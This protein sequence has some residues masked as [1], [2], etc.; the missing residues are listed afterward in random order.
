MYKILEIFHI[1]RNFFSRNF[2]PFCCYGGVIHDMV[3][4]PTICSNMTLSDLSSI[5][6]QLSCP[7][8]MLSYFLPSKRIIE[9]AQSR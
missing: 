8:L 9:L 2:L 7:K 1:T 5:H 4:T 6:S 3:L